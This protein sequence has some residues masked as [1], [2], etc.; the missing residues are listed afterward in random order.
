MVSAT[1]H[2]QFYEYGKFILTESDKQK[3]F[4]AG[5][6]ISGISYEWALKEFKDKKKAA[7]FALGM[8]LAAGIV[9][10]SHDNW[11]GQ[12]SYFDNRDIL[13]TMMGSVT[14][15]IPLFALQKPKKRYKH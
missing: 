9:K 5:V 12:P 8:S 4:V 3:H 14:I 11:R 1:M 7:A 6:V 15:T 2:G 13:A 10:E